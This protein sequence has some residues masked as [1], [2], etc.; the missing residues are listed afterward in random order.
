MLSKRFSVLRSCFGGGRDI[1]VLVIRS[2]RALGSQAADEGWG[3]KDCGG[4]C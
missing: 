4:H 3:K 1:L 2:G